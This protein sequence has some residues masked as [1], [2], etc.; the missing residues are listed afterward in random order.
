MQQREYIS[1]QYEFSLL[2]VFRLELTQVLEMVAEAQ[3]AG[4]AFAVQMLAKIG[5][6]LPKAVLKAPANLQAAV[7]HLIEAAE[8]GPPKATKAAVRRDL[9]CTSCSNVKNVVTSHLTCRDVCPC[10]G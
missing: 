5:R 10:E 9:T 3:S 6:H 2:N 8:N 4:G 1:L 7:P